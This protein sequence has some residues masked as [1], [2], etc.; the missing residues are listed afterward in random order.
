MKLLL[1]LLF[2]AVAV[3]ADTVIVAELPDTPGSAER[4]ANTHDLTH[5]GKLDYL[6]SKGNYHAFKSETGSVAHW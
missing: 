2:C 3:L 5:V 4:Y 1:L 6:A